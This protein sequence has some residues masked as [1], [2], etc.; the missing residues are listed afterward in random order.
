VL[1][2]IALGA[3]GSARAQAQQQ[4]RETRTW[5]QAY[6]DAQAKIQKQ[7]WRG[8]LNDLD[9]ATRLGAPRPARNVNFYGD[10]YRDYNPDYYRAMALNGLDRYDE[11]DQALERVRQAQLITSRDRLNGEFTRLSTSVKAN[12]QKLAAARANGAAPNGL[13]PNGP[14]PAGVNPTG[15]APAG[16]NAANVNPANANPVAATGTDTRGVVTQGVNTQ[17]GAAPVEPSKAPPVANTNAANAIKQSPVQQSRVQR[18]PTPEQQK[19]AAARP[20]PTYTAAELEL[21]A[22]A[23]NAET[24]AV[25]QITERTTSAQ[26]ERE[27]LVQFFSGRYAQADGMLTQLAATSS[28]SA[29]TFYYLACAR[30]AMVYA[31]QAPASTLAE[32]REIVKR[33]GGLENFAQ[34]FAVTSPR[35]LRELGLRQ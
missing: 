23:S 26:L 22:K 7:D 9:A 12:V 33:A 2:A 8:A 24:R 35:I 27:A 15:I 19:R 13:S 6:A 30:V 17:G 21:L 1:I 14:G 29:R 25:Q 32:A 20:A 16:V 31:G 34:D 3:A 10:V 5:Y 4:A 28:P 18:P 11:A